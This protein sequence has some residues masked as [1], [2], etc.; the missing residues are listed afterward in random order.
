MW[1]FRRAVAKANIRLQVMNA[2]DMFRVHPQ[3]DWS[4]VCDG[5]QQRVGIYPGGQRVI[6]KIG[7]AHVTIICNRCLPPQWDA[8]APEGTL[9]E[10]LESVPRQAPYRSFI[11]GRTRESRFGAL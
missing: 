9:T 11:A 6:K 2:D 3:T 10:V 8:F 1:W 5:C 4:F 7:R